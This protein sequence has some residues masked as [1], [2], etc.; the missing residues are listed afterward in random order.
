[1]VTAVEKRCRRCG[2][3]LPA[4]GFNVNPSNG[5]GLQSWCKQCS[6]ER[7]RARTLADPAIR[8]AEHLRRHF[9]LRRADYDRL[10]AEQGGRCNICGTSTPSG[11]S[12]EFFSVDHDHQT[13]KI[14]GLLCANCNHGLGHFR[15]NSEVLQA[16][17]EYLRDQPVS[18]SGDII[19]FSGDSPISDFVN[20]M[21]LGVPRWSISHV[22][23]LADW[24]GQLL[25]F[26]STTLD[27]L[28]CEIT[29]VNWNGTQRTNS[30]DV[31]RVYKGRVWEY[32]LVRPLYPFESERL[33]SFLLGT[34]HLPYDQVV[35]MRS[36]GVGLSRMES[37]LRPEDLRTIFCSEWVAKALAE[38][39]LH[40][41]DDEPLESEQAGA[42]LAAA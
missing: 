34:L 26:E 27:G 10:L 40:P 3:I 4:V 22:G 19:G 30:D 28:P 1:M 31:L 33:S 14:R 36:A 6:Q 17:I 24:Q 42:S 39:G 13:G 25:L 9:G 8:H 11:R 29:K 38:V 23:V 35:A 12:K 37:L 5:D 16:A 32:P 18:K 20:L 7:Q 41:T 21:T 2:R 15:D